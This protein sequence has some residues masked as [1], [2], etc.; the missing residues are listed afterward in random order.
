MPRDFFIRRQ[1]LVYLS[2]FSKK[3]QFFSK[4]WWKVVESGDRMREE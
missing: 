2:D 1:G 3:N 4:K